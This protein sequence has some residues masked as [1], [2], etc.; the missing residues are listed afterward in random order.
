MSSYRA[1]HQTSVQTSDQLTLIVMLYDGAIRNVN[2]ALQHLKDDEVEKTHNCLVKAKN[3]VTEL[4][5]TLNMEQG[6][7]I[8][9]NLQSLGQAYQLAQDVDDAIP[10]L[11]DAGE[12]SDDGEIFSRLSQLYLEKDQYKKCTDAADSALKKGLD[13]EYNAEIV[14]GMCLFNRDRLTQARSTFVTARRHARADKNESVERICNQWITYIDRD[15][16]RRDQLAKAEAE[17]AG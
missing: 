14:L 6:G 5:S 7:E 11:E 10:V 1:Y 2:F 9:K 16:I 17:F 12:L 3:I 4:L 15:R 13:R 8:A